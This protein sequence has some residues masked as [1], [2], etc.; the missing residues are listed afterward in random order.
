M[1]GGAQLSEFNADL[2]AAD[3]DGVTWKFVMVPEPIQ[4]LGVFAATDRFEGYAFE[5]TRILK[6]IDEQNIQNVVFIAADV[7]GTFVNNLSYQTAP[8]TAQ[9]PVDSFEI[10][11]GPVAFDAPLGPTVANALVALGFLTPAQKAFYDSLPSAGQDAFIELIANNLI[12]PLGYD[13]VELQGSGID[14]TLLQG[15]YT[16]VHYYGWTEFDIGED[17]HRLT[18]TTYGSRPYSAADIL[19]DPAGVLAIQPTVVSQFVVNPK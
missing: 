9:I 6:F 4:N 14:A 3:S 5:R 12:V 13:P 2:L 15:S 10:T 19:A 18:V 17:D 11:T 7:H 16:A 1:L 8:F